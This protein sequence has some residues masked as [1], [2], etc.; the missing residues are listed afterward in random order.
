MSYTNKDIKRF[1]KLLA[2]CELK[3]FDNYI[4][5]IARLDLKMFLSKFTKKEQDKMAKKIGAYKK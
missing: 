4:R 3:G 2:Q 5:N 1:D